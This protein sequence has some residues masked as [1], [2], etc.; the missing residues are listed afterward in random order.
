M[1]SG[2]YLGPSNR[3]VYKFSSK[4]DNILVLGPIYPKTELRVKS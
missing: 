1:M 4:S 2:L 3:L